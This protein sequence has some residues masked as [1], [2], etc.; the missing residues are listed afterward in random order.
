[1]RLI[2]LIEDLISCAYFRETDCGALTALF[3]NSFDDS[4]GTK[5]PSILLMYIDHELV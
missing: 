4:E 1:M 5:I 3:G 2:R